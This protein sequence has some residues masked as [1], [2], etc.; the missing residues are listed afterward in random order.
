MGSPP[1]ECTE[2][3]VDDL[4]QHFRTFVENSLLGVYRTT[5]GGRVLLANP[6][7]AR[8]LGFPSVA[9]LVAT[10]MEEWAAGTRYPRTRFKQALALDG[11]VDGFQSTFL[12]PDGSVVHLRESARAVRDRSGAIEYIEGFV[13]DLTRQKDLEWQLQQAQRLEA[14]GRLAGGVAHDFNNILQAMM[15]QAQ[16]MRMRP[17]VPARIDEAVSELEQE[18]RRGASLTRQLLLF[19]RREALKPERLELN[20]VVQAALRMLR[21]LVREEVVIREEL[22]ADPLPVD[23]DRVSSS[24]YLAIWSSTRP[25]RCRRE[26]RSPSAPPGSTVGTSRWLY[27][28]RGQAFPTTSATTSSSRSSPPRAKAGARGWGCRWFTAS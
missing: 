12:R 19:S 25:T 16:L 24:R 5:P 2:P 26:G 22:A 1:T 8:M 11:H 27:R 21:R 18:I 9:A 23:G 15:S 6:A 7:L 13:E 3:T 14:L 4:E 10:G 17:Q 28:T 20:G